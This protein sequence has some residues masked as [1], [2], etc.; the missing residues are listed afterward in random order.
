M[1][2]LSTKTAIPRNFFNFSAVKS[3]INYWRNHKIN[4]SKSGHA[5]VLEIALLVAP[6]GTKFTTMCCIRRAWQPF[7]KD[8]L[9]LLCQKW[10]AGLC[11]H[12]ELNITP[13]APANCAKIAIFG[14]AHVL[15]I[16]D[17]DPTWCRKYQNKKCAN[18]NCAEKSQLEKW[19]E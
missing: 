18:S 13:R 14:H 5:V 8:I 16:S 1:A 2:P 7:R 12:H 9:R 15:N 3:Y 11:D 4:V 17:G 6:L 10:H 19:W